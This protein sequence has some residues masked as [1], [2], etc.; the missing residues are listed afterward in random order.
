MAAAQQRGRPAGGS[1]PDNATLGRWG[2]QA[3][4]DY[5]TGRGWVILERNWRCRDGELD[6][7]AMD[8]PVVVVCEVKTRT[9]RTAGSALESVTPRK[10]RRLH[11]LGSLWLAE[12]GAWPVGVRIDAV[13]IHRFPDGT[14][15]VEHVRGVC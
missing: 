15:T 3:A 10:L 13:G 12:R 7:V 1:H 11:R 9:S 5:L 2:E 4:A 14:Y 8:G 6:I